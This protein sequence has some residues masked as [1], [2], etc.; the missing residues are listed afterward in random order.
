MFCYIVIIL[1]DEGLLIKFVCKLSDK[2]WRKM[3]VCVLFF[4]YVGLV[5]KIENIFVGGY[6]YVVKVFIYWCRIVGC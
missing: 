3:V 1:I 4:W 2:M 6:L 5:V